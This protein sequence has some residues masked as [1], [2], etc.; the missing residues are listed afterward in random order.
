MA[1]H[2]ADPTDKEHT[3]RFAHGRRPRDK[4]KAKATPAR[5]TPQPAAERQQNWRQGSTGPRQESQRADFDSFAG[6]THRRTDGSEMGSS[7]ED[8]ADEDD[9]EEEDD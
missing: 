4:A 2:V 1:Q 9:E 3:F 5:S 8:D 7:A 6:G